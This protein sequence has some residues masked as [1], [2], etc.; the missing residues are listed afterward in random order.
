MFIKNY[1]LFDNLYKIKKKVIMFGNIQKIE[2]GINA[3]T[4]N[5]RLLYSNI[6]RPFNYLNYHIKLFE[7]SK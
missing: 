5:I 7:L 6:D 4:N 3:D 2:I 1:N